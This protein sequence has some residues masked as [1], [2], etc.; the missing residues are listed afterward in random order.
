MEV[1]SDT[2]YVEQSLTYPR[3]LAKRHVRHVQPNRINLP[4]LGCYRQ[5]ARHSYSSDEN[6][7]LNWLPVVIH[8]NF[9]G[10]DDLRSRIVLKI[11]VDHL[12]GFFKLFVCCKFSPPSIFRRNLAQKPIGNNATIVYPNCFPTSLS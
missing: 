5:K 8:I 3:K 4:P 10:E 9:T 2:P 1:Q 7:Q 11:P 6:V 12:I